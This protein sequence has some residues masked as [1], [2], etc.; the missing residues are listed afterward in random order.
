MTSGTS[1]ESAPSSDHPM[2][3]D[4]EHI[5]RSTRDRLE[6]ADKLQRW[7][8][9]ELPTGS[10]PVIT[11][12]VSPE[13]NGMSSETLLI[14]ASWSESHARSEHRL[15]ARMEPPGDAWPVFTNYDLGKQFR[16]MRLVREHTAV[17]IPETHWYEPDPRVLGSP[18]LVM[19][20]IEGLVPPDVLP[21]TFADNWVFDASEADRRTLQD[22]AIRALAGVHAI[23][24]DAYD[25]KFLEHDLPGETS[26]ERSVHHWR[27]YHDTVVGDEPSP[28]LAECF[29]WLIDNLPTDVH[30]DALS[31]GDARIG[32]MMFRDLE[33]VAVLDWE[34]V[35]VA[36]PE[37]DVGWLCY[38]H[39]FFHDLTVQ[40]GAPG[41]PHMLRPVD[42]RR[43]YADASSRSLGDL[44]WHIAD[45]AIRHAL[46]VRR[47]AERSIFF[48]EAPE[49]DDIDD[50]IMH[51]STL[52]G[53]LD[54]SYW[55]DVA[56]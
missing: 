3:M 31:W 15:V 23:T 1:S 8:A 12:A 41:L 25:L 49:P 21:Y 40:L 2:E 45:A 19:D 48:G 30:G 38:L 46:N 52:R 5:T 47:V 56:L 27:Q 24:P 51:R 36:P 7:L 32:N 35:E 16:V 54:G 42:V 10:N 43:T 50:L 53:M 18:L 26:L 34:M 14:T 20:R 6:T 37:V 33:V 28:L 13:S 22:S 44:R 55:S 9:R 29:D 39:L 11:E 4:A 17:P